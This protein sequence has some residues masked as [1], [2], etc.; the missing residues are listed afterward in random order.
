MTPEEVIPDGV[1]VWH[2]TAACLIASPSSQLP[3]HTVSLCQRASVAGHDHLHPRSRNPGLTHQIPVP[4]SLKQQQDMDVLLQEGFG[5]DQTKASPVGYSLTPE[6]CDELR[7]HLFLCWEIQKGKKS[8]SQSQRRLLSDS[9]ACFYP[10]TYSM[11]TLQ[12][13]EMRS[14][15]CKHEYIAKTLNRN[16]VATHIH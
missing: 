2:P 3:G 16:T 8:A 13:K 14:K 12:R 9:S 6:P 5:L 10:A 1:F 11:P 15:G 7:V 4:R